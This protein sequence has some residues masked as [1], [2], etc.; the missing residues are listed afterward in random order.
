MANLDVNPGLQRSVLFDRILVI[1]Y[2]QA[3]AN[4]VILISKDCRKIICSSTL[5]ETHFILLEF[6]WKIH[7]KYSIKASNFK[8]FVAVVEE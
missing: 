7:P 8:T 6:L 5:Y 2:L 1:A 4:S 3:I